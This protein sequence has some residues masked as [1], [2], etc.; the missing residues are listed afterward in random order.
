MDT[1]FTRRCFT[2]SGAASNAGYVTGAG[3]GGCGCSSTGFFNVHDLGD[4]SGGGG[5]GECNG[6]GGAGGEGGR[7]GR[8][9]FQ[10]PPPMIAETIT[11]VPRSK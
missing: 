10:A 3:G 7:A 5:C 1:F 2:R 9:G 6:G 11:C 4:P 8:R